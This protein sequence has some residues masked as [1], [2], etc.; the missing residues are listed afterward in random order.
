MTYGD[1]R[2]QV[3]EYT[4]SDGDT[5]FAARVPTFVRT[6]EA[7]FRRDFRLPAQEIVT[8]LTPADQ[9]V[10]LPDGFQEARAIVQENELVPMVTPTQLRSF[11]EFGEAGQNFGAVAI[12]GGGIRTLYATEDVELTLHYFGTLPALDPLDDTST[13]WLLDN[14][15]DIYREA[16]L[17]EAYKW[18]QEFDD[19]MKAEAAYV[20]RKNDLH[21]NLQAYWYRGQPLRRLASPYRTDPPYP[22]VRHRY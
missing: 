12:E 13:N 17:A 5:V 8:K 9:F 11:S 18:L 20:S 10:A 6:A 2:D 16:T 14:H 3:I 19:E 15:P 4:A 7:R 22:Q 21:K 1:L